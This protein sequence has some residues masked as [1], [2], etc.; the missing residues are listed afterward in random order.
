[1]S[2][3]GYEIRARDDEKLAELQTQIAHLE[4]MLADATK[5]EA[6][7]RTSMVANLYDPERANVYQTRQTRRTA[8]Q[9]ELTKLEGQARALEQGPSQ[10]AR[11]DLTKL[12]REKA[13]ELAKAV[14]KE[15]A[16]CDR[17]GRELAQRILDELKTQANV[18]MQ[19]SGIAAEVSDC[20]ANPGALGLSF[21]SADQ[22]R[23]LVHSFKAMI[24]SGDRYRDVRILLGDLS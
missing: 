16:R 7:A 23:A 15:R 8:L 11:R 5:A 19:L 18:S 10:E 22:R 24:G 12:R 20:Q 3:Y 17:A 21:T 4:Q 13:A 9:G 2:E 6:E 1:V 14:E